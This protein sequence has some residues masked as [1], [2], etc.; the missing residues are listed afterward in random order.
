M[1]GVNQAYSIVK[2]NNP[3]MVALTCAL[4][5]DSYVFSLIPEDLGPNDGF[6]NG[7]VYTVS[8]DTG[9]Y[10]VRYAMDMFNV[11]IVNEI[12]VNTLT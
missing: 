8:C 12:D 2:H 4:T 11:P 5:K 3:G 9:E 7:A 10:N 1:L 6:A